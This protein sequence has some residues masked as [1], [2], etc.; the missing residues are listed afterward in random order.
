MNKHGNEFVEYV[1][2]ILEPVGPVTFKSMFGGF[3][4]YKNGRIFA[5][6]ID[7]ELYFKADTETGAAFAKQGS[8]QF[9]YT[10]KSGKV[11]KMCYWRVPAEILD[12][13]GFLQEWFALSYQV[14]CKSGSGK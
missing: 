9:S 3:G 11:V 13:S 14:A 2:E 6:I 1:A 8:E 7:N 10:I 4:I 5:I 12:D